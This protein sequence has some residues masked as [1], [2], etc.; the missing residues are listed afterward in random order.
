M[1]EATWLGIGE[2]E[3]LCVLLFTAGVWAV[4]SVLAPKTRSPTERQGWNTK[5][6]RRPV[7]V[8][9]AAFVGALFLGAVFAAQLWSLVTQHVTRTLS[10]N[11]TPSE[12]FSTIW[13]AIPVVFALVASSPVWLSLVRRIVTHEPPP[14]LGI[15][16]ILSRGS[17]II[18]AI[19]GFYG[20]LPI[21]ARILVER[22][23][24]ITGISV[25][26]FV[27]VLWNAIVGPA[28]IFAALPVSFWVFR[29]RI[30]DSAPPAGRLTFLTPFVMMVAA[31]ITATSGIPSMALLFV[32]ICCALGVGVTAAGFD[33][34]KSAGT[35]SAPG[36]RS[37]LARLL[38]ETVSGAALALTIHHFAG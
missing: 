2:K 35:S 19:C 25:R 20:V 22:H 30:V 34:A 31:A 27:A 3:A 5:N 15:R 10:S 32:L 6:L 33:F 8:A 1:Q 16:S 23:S 9:A 17:F 11:S 24:D 28:T 4:H 37:W 13:I 26:A 12:A 21:A 29:P 18:G 7:A 14:G 38:V 36:I